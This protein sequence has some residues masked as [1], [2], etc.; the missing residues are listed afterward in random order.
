MITLLVAD[1]LDSFW[2][3][4]YWKSHD[5]VVWDTNCLLY[6]MIAFELSDWTIWERCTVLADW[7]NFVEWFFDDLTWYKYLTVV[8]WNSGERRTWNWFIIRALHEL[9]FRQSSCLNSL[10]WVQKFSLRTP[11]E[12]VDITVKISCTRWV[13][14]NIQIWSFGPCVLTYGIFVGLCAW[15]PDIVVS[16][17]SSPNY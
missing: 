11:K 17:I 9:P 1:Q 12:G 5:F 8:E 14:C 16:F 13:S 4:F 15:L 7:E 3:K 6:P 2:V 10:N